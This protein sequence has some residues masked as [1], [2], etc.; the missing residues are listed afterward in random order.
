[1]KQFLIALKATLVLTVLTGL[2]YPLLVTCLSKVLFPR[3]PD[4]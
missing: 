3:H 1:M 4:S 2:M